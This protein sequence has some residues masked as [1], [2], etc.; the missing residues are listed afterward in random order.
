MH[1]NGEVYT[2]CGEIVPVEILVN[3]K[4]LCTPLYYR[5]YSRLRSVS[6]YYVMTCV[7]PGSLRRIASV[8][9]CERR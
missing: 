5:S 9:W 3:W 1:R 2:G 4:E 8:G 7:I 6:T